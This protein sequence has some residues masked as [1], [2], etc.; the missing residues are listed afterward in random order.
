MPFWL[1]FTLQLTL[2][3]LSLCCASNYRALP[4]KYLSAERRI[5][6]RVAWS[7]IPA[8]EDRSTRFKRSIA[9]RP[10]PL[11]SNV[12]LTSRRTEALH[13]YY[14]PR[15]N[16]LASPCSPLRPDALHD[17]HSSRCPL[18]PSLLHRYPD[19][20]PL[21]STIHSPFLS[22]SLQ[23]PLF[24]LPT[25]PSLHPPF[26]P[27]SYSTRHPPLPLSTSPSLHPS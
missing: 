17:A 1:L 6:S 19:T 13:L 3:C 11:A 26:S 2:L 21:Y 18:H 7:R 14:L 24:P 27:T 4:G 20:L 23:P 12:G 10:A 8:R 25:T 15:L 22:Y 16:S 5:R 9:L